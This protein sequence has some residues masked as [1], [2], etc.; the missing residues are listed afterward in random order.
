MKNEFDYDGLKFTYD[1]LSDEFSKEMFLNVILYRL[2]PEIH[3]RFPMFYANYYQRLS[4]LHK[5]Y[6]SSSFINVPCGGLYH[7]NLNK[8]GYDIELYYFSLAIFVD[9]I[10][11]QYR[12]KNIVKAQ[13]GDIVID[14]G[15]CYGDTALYFA[16]EV[17]SYGKVYSFEF[18]KENIEIFRKNVDLNP[19]F[20]DVIELVERPLG[21][22]SEEKLYGISNFGS[23]CL[24]NSFREGCSIYKTIA[25]DDFVKE[26]Q[27]PIVN[28]IK[29]DVEG[30]EMN[31]LIGAKETIIKLKPKLAVCLYHKIEDLWSILKFLKDLVPEYSFY[32]NHYTIGQTETILYAIVDKVKNEQ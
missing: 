27:L 4:D 15:G 5:L 30:A 22:N 16:H 17:G 28:Y 18:I 29:L 2:F 9:F 14:G 19:K 25:I 23:S 6:A 1:N 11:E 10:E 20:K 21:Q 12:Y 13:K 31:A 7:Y 8:I 24:L 3:F 26:K 32:L